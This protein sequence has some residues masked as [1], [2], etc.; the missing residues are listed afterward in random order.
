MAIMAKRTVMTLFTKPND[1]YSHQVR[2]VLAEKGLNPEIVI[3]EDGEPI[4]ASLLK[5][6]PYGTCPSLFDRELGL[7]EADIIMEYI[8]ERFPHPPLLPV[9]PVARAE[10]RKMMYRIK[11]DFYAIFEQIKITGDQSL[12]DKLMSSLVQLDAIFASK[13]FF[14]SDEFSLLDCVLIPLLWRL[15]DLEMAIPEHAKGLTDY[16]QRMFMR[17]GFQSSLTD[18]EKQARVA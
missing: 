11:R 3:V 5:F 6:N 12:K 2:I 9:Y 1:L 13:P 17:S 10:T 14:L 8:D 7:Y 4:P 15:Q 16:T 18:E